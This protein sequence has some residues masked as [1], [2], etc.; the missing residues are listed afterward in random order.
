VSIRELSKRRGNTF[1]ISTGWRKQQETSRGEI[2]LNR[3]SVYNAGPDVP[4]DQRATGTKNNAHG[5][6]QSR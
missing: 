2:S 1:A 3:T 6:G 4:S 5:W